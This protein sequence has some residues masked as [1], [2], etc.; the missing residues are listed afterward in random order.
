MVIQPL[1]ERERVEKARRYT[2]ASVSEWLQA[3]RKR[4]RVAYSHEKKSEKWLQ[5][6]RSV[7]KWHTATGKSKKWPQA[8]QKVRLYFS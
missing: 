5:A 1:R 6:T 8:M 2:G 3:T 4:G 7:R